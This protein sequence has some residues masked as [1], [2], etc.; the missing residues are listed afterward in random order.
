M[1][2]QVGRVERREWDSYIQHREKLTTSHC[3][4][5]LCED[6]W[7]TESTKTEGESVGG[8]EESEGIANF[9]C[10]IQFRVQHLLHQGGEQ[11]GLGCTKRRIQVESRTRSCVLYPGYT[12]AIC[13]TASLKSQCY[14]N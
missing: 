11:Y 13:M 9:I 3:A 8:G 2:E 1:Y 12:E 6:D 14:T 5:E 10:C 7:V 4:N